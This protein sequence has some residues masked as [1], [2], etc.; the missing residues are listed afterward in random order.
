MK[1]QCL[2][3]EFGNNILSK[4][5][6]SLDKKK[7]FVN[8]WI[9]SSKN[10]KGKGKFIFNQ[11]CINL[12]FK[13]SKKNNFKSIFLSKH[14]KNLCLNIL[15]RQM[16]FSKISHI[17]K[18]KFIIN[19]YFYWKNFIIK[20]KIKKVFFNRTP[21]L[22]YSYII[23]LVSK[24][25]K[26]KCLIFE[27]SKYIPYYYVTNDL[28]KIQIYS[29]NIGK[30]NSVVKKYMNQFKNNKKIE[31]HKSYDDDSFFEILKIIY[32]SFFRPF[33]TEKNI[34]KYF[35]HKNRT[36]FHNYSK[37]SPLD[38]KSLHTKFY[39]NFIYLKCY[40]YSKKLR[41]KYYKISK[42]I[43]FFNDKKS[44]YILFA[45][46]FQ[47]EKST[48]PDGGYYYNHFDIL[49]E[50]DNFCKKNKLYKIIYK[51]H[52]S[53]FLSKRFGFIEKDTDFYDKI[54]RLKNIFFAKQYISGKRLIDIC[55]LTV[56]ATS[57]LGIQSNLLGK[58][59]IVFGNVWFEKSPGIFKFK[60]NDNF[61]KLFFSI[62]KLKISK[63]KLQNYFNGLDNKKNIFYYNL[64]KNNKQLVNFLRR[65]I[66]N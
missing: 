42:D 8:T 65:N 34:F 43:S 4:E 45:A 62:N 28:N 10:F 55:E 24:K 32:R 5:I 58:P 20:N 52:P 6:L 59:A 49:K 12:N 37:Y 61:E 53:Q 29:K 18:K 14:E 25:L 39:D 47:P 23:Y 35:F 50:L 21:H 44:K 7:R 27:E 40:L 66:L 30:S 63:K 1:N 3:I 22:L 11:D 64:K 48:S 57:E 46:N 38:I 51:E 16:P 15:R 54:S 13:L 26:L 19:H 17:D 60:K 33:L 41:K 9:S 36:R 56:T 31:S 2:F